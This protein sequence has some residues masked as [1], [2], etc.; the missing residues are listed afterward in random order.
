M[1]K[2]WLFLFAAIASLN[3]VFAQD[4]TARCNP[5]FSLV[6]QDNGM[7][8]IPIFNGDS[9]FITKHSWNFGDGSA[10][11]NDRF[12][13]HQYKNFGSYMVTHVIKRT[14]F[15]GDLI[16][17]DSMQRLVYYQCTIQSSFSSRYDSLVVNKIYF[18]NNSTSN[19]GINSVRWSF[20]DGTYSTETNPTH[21]YN[22]S[23]LFNVCLSVKNSHCYDDTCL[24]IQVKGPAQQG[25]GISSNFSTAIDSTAFYKIRFTNLST[26]LTLSDSVQWSFGDSSFSSEINPVHIFP[27]AGTYNVC[28]RIK[29]KT[30]PG[31]ATCVVEYCSPVTV[32]ER[33]YLAANFIFERDSLANDQPYRYSFHDLY[34]GANELDSI[35]WNFGDGSPLATGNLNPVHSYAK[36]GVY[37]VCLTIKQRSTFVPSAYCTAA[38]CKEIEIPVINACP[39]NVSFG[40][41]SDNYFAQ[42]LFFTNQTQGADSTATAHWN[43]GDGKESN[44]WNAEHIYENAGYHNV[45]LRITQNDSCM[46]E[47]CSTLYIDSITPQPCSIIPSFVTRQDSVH[48]NKFYFFNTTPGDQ[49]Y[50][51]IKW[52]F[53][54]STISYDENP[55]HTYSAPGFYSV[56]LTI[57]PDSSCTRSIYQRVQAQTNDSCMLKANFIAQHGGLLK[58]MIF[59]NASFYTSPYTTAVWDFGD[60]GTSNEW[61]TEHVFKYTGNYTVCLKITDSI[62]ESNSCYNVLVDSLSANDSCNIRAS[63]T[64]QIDSTQL[65]NIYFN[66]NSI[67]P[68]SNY[69]FKWDFGDGSFSRDLYASHLYAAPG[70]YRVCLTVRKDSICVSDT[71]IT[72]AVLS[73]D[74]CSVRADFRISAEDNNP[75]KVHFDNASVNAAAIKKAYWTFGDG[76]SS[77]KLSPTHQY[78][79]PGTYYICLQEESM[80]HCISTKCDSIVI[81]R[82]TVNCDSSSAKFTYQRDGYLPNKFY[83]FASETKPGTQYNWNFYSFSGSVT[84]SYEANPAH[85]FTD[86]GYYWVCLKNISNNGCTNDYC[87]QVLITDTSAAP[88]CLLQAYPNPAHNNLFI[89]LEMKKQEQIQIAVFNMQNVLLLQQT[90]QGAKG[91][92]KLEVNMQKL[93]PGFYV[94]RLVYG[95]QVCYAKFQKI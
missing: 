6:I 69:Q 28:L 64:Y 18:N 1:K 56:M 33:C 22:A 58:Q 37:H 72:V 30:A 13:F 78:A 63:F 50:Y 73:T 57:Q 54:D 25:C 91:N 2:I 95:S 93:V 86:T 62:C 60:G 45:C 76:H 70:N 68:Q 40:W 35:A 49:H 92:N 79:A 85:V 9:S 67:N 89:N 10:I 42:K 77:D 53:G 3:N 8:F 7:S 19:A 32:I 20:G 88:Q 24:S 51:S 44:T 38:V 47:Y 84:V 31:T 36:P 16:C 5:E 48:Q 27:A 26:P 61:N 75:F 14:S 29:K 81:A 55:V 11:N 83:F 94:M 90:K 4:T 34:Y 21:T 12:P 41:K 87:E 71:C 43:F 59:T 65:N 17:I 15:N 23:G 66:N 39:T 46:Q 82:P 80:K 52:D 74:R